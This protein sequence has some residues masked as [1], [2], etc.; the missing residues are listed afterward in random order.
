LEFIVAE[1]A[2]ETINAHGQQ[3]GLAKPALLSEVGILR[4]Q[5]WGGST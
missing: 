3:L 2:A 4:L 5:P 1:G